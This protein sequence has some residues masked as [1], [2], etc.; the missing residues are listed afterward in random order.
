MFFKETKI[1]EGVK[2]D[3]KGAV[4]SVE[5]PKG[6]LEKQ[7]EANRNTKIEVIENKVRVSSQEDDRQT[8]A[9]VGTITAHIRNAMGGVSNGYQYKL[10]IIYSHFPV[11]VKVEGS[12]FLVQNFLGERTP[13]VANIL[14]NA[15]VKIEGAEV[16]VDGNDLEEVSQTAANIEQCCRIVGY[17]KKIFQDGIYITSKGE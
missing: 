2:V 5:G 4:V 14:G 9:L 10:K 6:K 7:T 12:K 3:V 15:K 13:R 17:D 1:P 8:K 16:L 11:T